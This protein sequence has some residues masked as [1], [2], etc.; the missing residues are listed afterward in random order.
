MILECG[1]EYFRIRMGM[2]N[3]TPGWFSLAVIM[4]TILIWEGAL[5]PDR[6]PPRSRTRMFAADFLTAMAVFLLLGAAVFLNEPFYAAE[7]VAGAFLALA[8]VVK[9]VQGILR[10]AQRLFPPPESS[11]Q[12]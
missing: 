8:L 1:K 11:S 12:A 3:R 7:S 4:G 9:T 5:L 6:I 10:E 2:E